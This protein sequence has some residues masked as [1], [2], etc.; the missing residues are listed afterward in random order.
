MLYICAVHIRYTHVY[1]PDSSSIDKRKE[2]L[3]S[4]QRHT[5]VS[6]LVHLPVRTAAYDAVGSCAFLSA[7]YI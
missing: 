6:A 3:V 1:S 7:A 5:T 2:L 4:E